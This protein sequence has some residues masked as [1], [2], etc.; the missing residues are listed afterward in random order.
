MA[1]WEL[2][3]GAPRVFN[4]ADGL[5][6]DSALLEELPGNANNFL[7]RYTGL[8]GA[9][10]IEQ[11][12]GPSVYP[13]IPAGDRYL[14]SIDLVIGT[15]LRI[16]PSNEYFYIDAS[17]C[18]TLAEPFGGLA[19]FYATMAKADEH[20]YANLRLEREG[21]LPFPDGFVGAWRA[22]LV[23]DCGKDLPK[24]FEKSNSVPGKQFVSGLEATLGTSVVQIGHIY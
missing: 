22:A 4:L 9:V 18:E 1:E 12:L 2:K 14:Q 19:P 16:H 10:A 8:E 5:P 15:Q 17:D 11:I 13:E 21:K 7:V 3:A 23:L 24:I 20:S 6:T